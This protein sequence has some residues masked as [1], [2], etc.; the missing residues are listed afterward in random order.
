MQRA[1]LNLLLSPALHKGAKYTV[2]V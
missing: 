1:L 2:V